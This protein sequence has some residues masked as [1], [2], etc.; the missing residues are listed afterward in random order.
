MM[1]GNLY[2]LVLFVV[3]FSGTNQSVGEQPETAE[4]F[5]N[6]SINFPDLAP[7]KHHRPDPVGKGRGGQ[8][9]GGSL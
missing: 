2:I 1:K 8:I 4:D 5:L 9:L 7:G 6:G 3:V